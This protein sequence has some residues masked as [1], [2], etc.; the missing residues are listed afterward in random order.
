MLIDEHAKLSTYKY[1]FY[2]F[3]AKILRFSTDLVDLD[4]ERS[5]TLKKRE[6]MI[7]FIFC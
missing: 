5:S 3:L 4:R 1:E 2:G 6:V 7:N